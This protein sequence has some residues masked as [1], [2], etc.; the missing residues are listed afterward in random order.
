M[1]I[2]KLY[3]ISAIPKVLIVGAGGI[4]STVALYLAAAGLPLTILDFDSVD[5]SNLHRYEIL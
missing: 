3:T 1:Y 2:L 4:G 5:K